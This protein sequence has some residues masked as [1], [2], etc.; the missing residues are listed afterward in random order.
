MNT[1]QNKQTAPSFPGRNFLKQPIIVRFRIVLCIVI[2][3]M[4]LWPRQ[5]NGQGVGI[6]EV[7]ITPDPSSILEL[8][9]VLRGFLAPRMTTLER[10]SIPSPVQGLLVYDTVSRSFWYFEGGWKSI[11]AEDLGSGNQQLSISIRQKI[12]E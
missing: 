8:R 12:P 4:A 11:A 9:S 10:L 5:V 1:V 6:S 2:M 3:I 7:T